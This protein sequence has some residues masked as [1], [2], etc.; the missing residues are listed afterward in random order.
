MCTV[1]VLRRNDGVMVTMNRDEALTRGPESPPKVVPYGDGWWVGPIDS[2]RGGTW[3][4]A[5][6]AGVVACL[7]N[8]Y[9]PDEDLLPDPNANNPSR[10]EIIPAA[11][12]QGDHENI[13]AWLGE[14]FS[15]EPYPSF[16]LFVIGPE[17]AYRHTWFR[18]EGF[19]RK[20][21]AA[22][23]HM[24][25][26]S[27]W[28]SAEVAEWRRNRF[29]EWLRS[30]ETMPNGAPEFHFLREPGYE[31]RSPLMLRSWSATR[32]VTQVVVD[33]SEQQMNFRYWNAPI[34]GGSPPDSDKH[35]ELT[36][37]P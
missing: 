1:S 32:S 29:E 12:A 13:D 36:G 23:A 21:L 4:G 37:C 25:T 10:G 7:L 5:N 30:G 16:M 34:P 35:L 17:Q 14:S 28:D 27:G 26:S 2:D 11:L 6:D 9:R 20:P 18:G 22:P 33:Y 31:E 3:I 15:P 24:E 8:A 19:R